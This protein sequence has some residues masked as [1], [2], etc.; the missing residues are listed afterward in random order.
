MNLFEL[1]CALYYIEQQSRALLIQIGYPLDR[2]PS[3]TDARA[4]WSEVEPS[5]DTRVP[6]GRLRTLSI[7]AAEHPGHGGAGSMLRGAKRA[8]DERARRL[9]EAAARSRTDGADGGP[10]DPRLVD[11]DSPPPPPD[12]WSADPSPTAYPDGCP[13]LTL[14]GADLPNEFRN[15][16]EGIVGRANVVPLYI[17]PEESAVGVPDPGERDEDLRRHIQE[18]MRTYARLCR[19]TYRKFSFQPYLYETLVV[20]GPDTSGYKLAWVPATS[21]PGDIAAAIVGI[22]REVRAGGKEGI[23]RVVIDH[24]RGEIAR[25]LDPYATLHDGGVRG[26]DRLRV[27]PE[28]IA[29][30]LSP[31]VRLEALVRAVAQLRGYAAKHP[32]FTL[33]ELDDDELP[34]RMIVELTVPGFAPSP[35]MVD[36]VPIRSH[37]VCLHLGPMFPLAAPLAV[38]ETPVFH[39]NICDSPRMGV[40]DG[41]LLFHPLLMEHSPERDFAALARVLT[42]VARYR[43]YDLSDGAS[44]PNPAAAAWA[45]TAFG[46]ELI[47]AFGGRPKADAVRDGDRRGDH[48]RLLRITPLGEV[49]GDH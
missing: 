34:T 17:T 45:A 6:N 32:E 37:R 8:A 16:M 39:P 4:F 33:V 2:I 9:R 42:D 26:G 1:L 44:A 46:Q 11:E 12:P 31:E 36:P 19:V 25:R 21:T 43:D 24:E 22:A 15:E 41:T 14:Y 38:W 47:T 27:A 28:A 10:V 35:A 30:G 20:F 29:G 3:F 49:P 5:L 18:R 23:V 40:P 13:T 48:S 7:V